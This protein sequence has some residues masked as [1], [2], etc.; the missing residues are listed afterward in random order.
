MNLLSRGL[1][2]YQWEDE[3]LNRILVCLQFSVRVKKEHLLSWCLSAIVHFHW[4]C[5]QQTVKAASVTADAPKLGLHT[6]SSLLNTLYSILIFFSFCIIP[7]GWAPMITRSHLPDYNCSNH[8][9]MT[10]KYWPFW[11]EKC[12]SVALL[13]DILLVWLAAIET[14]LPWRGI[15]SFQQMWSEERNWKSNVSVLKVTSDLSALWPWQ[16][17]MLVLSDGGRLS[18]YTHHVWLAEHTVCRRWI[19]L[20]DWWLP[21]LM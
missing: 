16:I 12:F 5:G 6:F 13:V 20:T 2:L 1:W 3:E 17:K 19:P 11:R 4:G 15:I 9:V 10:D 8:E 7:H 14:I 21:H 18:G